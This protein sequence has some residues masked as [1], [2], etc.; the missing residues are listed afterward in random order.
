[1]TAT[2]TIKLT[3]NKHVNFREADTI[4]TFLFRLNTTVKSQTWAMSGISFWVNANAVD[5]LAGA[6]NPD[7]LFQTNA[8]SLKSPFPMGFGIGGSGSDVTFGGCS[9]QTG[10]VYV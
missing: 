4:V 8:K 1:M 2:D 5:Y 3:R 9:S 10:D 7:Y 6:Y